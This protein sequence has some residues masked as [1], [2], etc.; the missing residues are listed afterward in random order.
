VHATGAEIEEFVDVL[1]PDPPLPPVP[2][3]TSA[4]SSPVDPDARGTGSRETPSGRS[5]T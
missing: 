5:P 1:V 4:L 3:R 2:S